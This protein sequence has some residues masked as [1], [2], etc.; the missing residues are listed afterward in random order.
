MRMIYT[1]DEQEN[2]CDGCLNHFAT[3]EAKV[4]FGSG[5]G[6]DNVIACNLYNG[7]DTPCMVV[8]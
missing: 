8:G 1:T 5:V 2:L 7:P 6:D 3:C 4:K